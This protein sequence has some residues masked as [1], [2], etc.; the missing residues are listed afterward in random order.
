MAS[1][2]AYFGDF[3]D[4]EVPS[5]LDGKD[6][7]QIVTNGLMSGSQDL[8]RPYSGHEIGFGAQ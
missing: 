2:N 7:V 4:Y 1:T 5:V 8:D 6:E 3:P